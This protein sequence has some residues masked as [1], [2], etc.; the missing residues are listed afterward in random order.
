MPP[1][2]APQPAGSLHPASV[3]A[4]PQY[5]P[6]S[7]AFSPPFETPPAMPHTAAAAAAASAMS[8]GYVLQRIRDCSSVLGTPHEKPPAVPHSTRLQIVRAPGGF[9]LF[10]AANDFDQAD[11]DPADAIAVASTA[12]DLVRRI[13]DWTDAQPAPEFPA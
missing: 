13:R 5:D 11:A 3:A 10:G 9:I 8:E 1:K 6:R 4:L 2:K 12:D 7:V